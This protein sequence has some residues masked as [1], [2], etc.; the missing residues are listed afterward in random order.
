MQV[1]KEQISKKDTELAEKD[2]YIQQ[3][4]VSTCTVHTMA[5]FHREGG[6]RI[7]QKKKKN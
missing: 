1:L 3:L 4:K 6:P 7:P 5:G 2:V